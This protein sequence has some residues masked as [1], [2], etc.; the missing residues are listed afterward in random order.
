MRNIF[1]SLYSYFGRHRLLMYLLLGSLFLAAG[2]FAYQVKFEEDITSILPS[3][4]KLDKHRQIF[5]DSKFMDK[6]VVLV[7]MKDTTEANPDLLVQYAESFASTVQEYYSPFIR[8]AAYKVDDSLALQ[9]FNTIQQEIPI[10]LE[11]SDYAAIDSLIEPATLKQT[12]INNYHTLASPAG[13]AF[14]QMIQH[15]PVGISF[16]GLKKLQQLQFDENFELYDNHVVTRDHKYLLMFITPRYEP[17]NTTQNKLFLDGL[18]K[19][20]DSLA[21]TDFTSVNAEYFG[22]AAVSLGNAQQLRT[23]SILTQGITIVFLIAF[24]WFY[25]RKKRAPLLILLPIAFGA[26]F[27]LACI[28]F[29]QGHISI[30]AIA[31]GSVVLGIAVNYSLH[32][33]NHFRH[34]GNMEE[35]LRDLAFPLTIGSITTIGGFLC[36]Y[37]ANSAML[38]DLGLF[39]A[40]S[41]VGAAFFSLIFLPHLLSQK[42]SEQKN[43][44]FAWLE[45][46]AA[47]RPEFNK[48][49][50]IPILLL[51]IVF[52]FTSRNVRFESDMMNMNYMPDKLRQTENTLNKLNNYALQS[53]YIV[54]D[55]SNLDEALRN[56][57][58]VSATLHTLKEQGIVRR[59]SGVSSVLVSDSVQRKRIERWNDY[60]TP[61]KKSKLISTLKKEGALAGFRSNAFDNFENLL[62]KK[63]LPASGQTVNALTSGLLSD[64]VTI[65]SDKVSIV[66]LAKVPGNNTAPIYKA[67]EEDAKITAIDRKY[68]TNKFVEVVNS[69]FNRIAWMSSILVFTILLLTYGRIELALVSFIPMVTTWIWILGIMGLF[70]IEFNIINVIISALIFGLGDDYSLFIMDGLVQEYKT[71]KKNLSSYKSS[72]LLSAITTI[73]GLG[74][75]VF[76]QHPALRSIA[77]I[78][79]IGILSVVLM[80]QVMIPLLFN[81]IIKRRTSAKKFPLTLASVLK[82]VFAFTYFVFGCLLLTLIG[83]V[84]TRLN[85]FNREKSKLVYHRIL[86]KFARSIMYTMGNVKKNIINPLHEDFSRPAI[87]ISNHQSFLD[88]LAL[89]MLHPKLILFTNKWVWNSPFFG[90]VVRM[91]DYFPVTESV[92]Q[93]ISLLEDRVKQGYSIAIF[94]EGTR[95]EDGVLKR[96]HKGAFFLAEKLDLDVLP[97][98]IHGTGYTMPKKD[99][100]LKDG[101]ITLKFLDRIKPHDAHFGLTYSQRA[102][103]IGQHFRLQYD[104]LRKEIEVPA[105]FREQL[106]YNFLYKGPVLE[107]YMKIKVR[108]EKDY[109]LFNELLPAEGKILDIGCGYGFMAYMLNFAQ[110]GRKITGIDYDEDKIA[111][112]QHC[113]NRTGNLQFFHSDALQFQYDTYDAIILADV[114]HYLH[115]DTQ[116]KIIERCVEQLNDGGMIIIRDG[117]TELKETHRYTKM[118]EFFSTRVVRF[119]K[120]EV[121]NLHFFSD[122]FIEEL[123]RD[124]EVKMEKIRDSKITSNTLFIIKKE[125]QN[126]SWRSMISLS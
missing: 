34:K 5:K 16:L 116:A 86:Q 6:L 115:R 29:I 75:L 51:T 77:L 105:Y 43:R 82:S 89:I 58:K 72:I 76:A 11:E 114:L 23:D 7:S 56:N 101:T 24:L 108:L 93:S 8:K 13:I 111:T 98:L 104:V 69:D 4:R 41:L 17:T 92:E 103:N 3:D 14:R 25:F 12:M 85:P 122:K 20:M 55:G 33:F 47:Y 49:L 1:T 39:A 88:I 42:I 94:P 22:A 28:Y 106:K 32:V 83:V 125:R 54:S 27:S 119:N 71:G 121:K 21:A 18:D 61:E 2:F 67:F 31:S 65:G 91:A 99:Y 74:V 120:T 38:N 95:S 37:F 117:N 124:K 123:V 30:I 19:V 45:K 100:L 66:T 59:T 78:S 9:L 70:G 107:W 109:K 90:H 102:K 60:W 73:A 26:L 84:F 36:L 50:L 110:A 96:F 35:T 113:F 79:I 15:D 10:Y 81:I 118:T 53:V 126:S 57:E 112:A 44:S 52:V 87:V 97:I 46:A 68:I 63:Y 62:N 64:H 48:Y 40:F 80:S